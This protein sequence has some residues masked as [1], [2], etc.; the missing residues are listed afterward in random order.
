MTLANGIPEFAQGKVTPQLA[1]ATSRGSIRC[2]RLLS[3]RSPKL[4]GKPWASTWV[5]QLDGQFVLRAQDGA[6]R[7]D[8]LEEAPLDLALPHP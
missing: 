5:T 8:F 3:L 7:E 1:S 4:L 2:F 6:S